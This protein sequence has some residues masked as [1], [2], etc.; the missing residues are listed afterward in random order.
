MFER[1]SFEGTMTG[2]P[3]SI[4]SVK[5]TDRDDIENTRLYDEIMELPKW[6][7][8]MLMSA[9]TKARKEKFTRKN[10]RLY[11]NLSKSFTDDQLKKFFSVIRNQYHKNFF[12]V[13]YYLALRIS[14][15]RNIVPD[16]QEDIVR[17]YSHK[18]SRYEYIPMF[19]PV[20]SILKTN[21]KLDYSINSIRNKFSK[22]CQR[23]GI[24]YVYAPR[25]NGGNMHRLTTHSLR[26]TAISKL[27]KVVNG[28]P[29]KL[30]LFSRHQAKKQVGVVAVYTHYTLDDLREDLSKAFNSEN[31]A[32][33]RCLNQYGR[34]L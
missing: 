13:Q 33:Q 6:K 1:Y 12:L 25:K 27:A 24:N 34:S 19:E 32:R 5:S 22:Y 14:E 9:C 23:A 28:N 2:L 8:E 10:T 21:P 16:F 7:I 31:I 3:H 15:V 18:M 17:I 4:D 26:H 20:R 29:F 11:G 30:C